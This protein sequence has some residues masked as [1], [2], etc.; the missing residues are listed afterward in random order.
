[1]FPN[2]M[3]SHARNLIAIALSGWTAPTSRSIASAPDPEPGS[4]GGGGGDGGQNGG[5]GGGPPAPTPP[6]P[7]PP[8]PTP[9]DNS[10][11]RAMRAELDRRAK[12]NTD[13]KARLET[14]A[15]END[16]LKHQQ[17]MAGKSAEERARIETERLNRQHSSVL[18]ERETER[19]AARAERDAARLE[20]DTYRMTT[21][22]QSAMSKTKGVLQSA[23]DHAVRLFMAETNLRMED[24]IEQGKP[25]RM[26]ATVDGNDY[27]DN[28]DEAFAKWV[29]K[30]PHL[31]A[32][33]GGGGGTGAPNGGGAP[34]PN[35]DNM[36]A[37]N[38]IELGLSRMKNG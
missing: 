10:S 22:A 21:R 1:M 37:E 9:P 27:V 14:L 36:Q 5:G 15:K 35:M 38:L 4:G 12:E 23:Q 13:F 25:K 8:A 31:L 33:P 26:I 34:L 6:A 29:T 17:E 11:I 3:H 2:G 7:T 30:Y 16:D 32:H 24:A 18:K 19:D 20:L 28:V